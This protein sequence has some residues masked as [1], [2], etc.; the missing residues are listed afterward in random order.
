VIL[1]IVLVCSG[2]AAG[3][4]VVVV[5]VVVVCVAGFGFGCV[6][7]CALAPIVMPITSPKITNSVFII[8]N[9]NFNVSY[10]I[11]IFKMNF[12]SQNS[13]KILERFCRNK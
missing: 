9:L 3:V 4:C 8:S 2:A 7:V 6:C 10:L 11:K 12:M 1:I 5:V 13:P